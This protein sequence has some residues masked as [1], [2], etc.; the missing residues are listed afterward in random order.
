MPERLIFPQDNSVFGKSHLPILFA[1]EMFEI[2]LFFE[3]GFVHMAREKNWL[4]DADMRKISI[5]LIDEEM[6]N[7]TN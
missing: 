6:E 4:E 5:N 2:A 7:Y 1:L 3:I